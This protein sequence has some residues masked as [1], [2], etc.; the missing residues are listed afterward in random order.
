MP[1]QPRHV[2]ILFRRFM[3]FGEDVTRRLRRRARGARRAA[4]ARRRQVVPRPRGSR[5]DSRRAGGDRVARRRAVGL[6]DAARRAVR[7][8]R[9]DAARLSPSRTSV[10][11]R[12]ASPRSCRRR[13]ARSA[14]A[15]QLL[16]AAA[17]QPQLSPGRRHDHAAAERDPRPRR[18]RPAAGR[19]AGARQ[20][21]A[22]RRARAAVPRS[23]A[24]CRSAAS[25]RSCASRPTAD[26]RPKRRFSRRAATA[27]G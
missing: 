21:P 3:H 15:L 9:R 7:D 1:I 18:L 23:T 27:C 20:R 2:C 17:R 4:S 16:R 13:S 26:R 11:I 8:R 12:F 5:D 10:S 25:S 24:A 19:R 14:E 22:R 6:R